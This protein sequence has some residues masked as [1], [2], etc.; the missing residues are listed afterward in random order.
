MEYL[1]YIITGLIGFGGIAFFALMAVFVE[2]KIAAYIQDRVGPNVVGP[3]GLF[4]TFA[5]ILK[6]LMKEQIIPDAVDRRLFVLA[7][8]IVFISVFAGFAVIPWGAGNSAIS[9]SASLVFVIAIVS[10]EV[11]GMWMA[12]WSS[13]NKYSLLGAIR[14]IAQMV[15]YEIPVALALLSAV[16]LVGSLDLNEICRLQGIHGIPATSWGGIFAWNIFKY[17]HL[18]L[19]FIIYAIASLAECNRAPFDLPEA[20][21]EI[22]AGFHTEYSGFRFALF[23]LAEYSNM[24]LVSLL[25]VIVFWGGWN[26]PFPDI[27]F[28]SAA[29]EGIV[30]TN[31]L[32][33]WGKLTT[34]IPGTWSGNLWGTFWLLSKATLWVLVQMWIRWTF[35]RI[36]VDQLMSL[37]WK[38][39][40]PAGI[41]LVLL[42]GLIKIL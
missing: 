19:A 42:S 8:I 13:N 3:Y 22:I 20:E 10:V 31:S 37:C 29:G 6:L 7:P 27:S 30:S 18:I 21:S 1:P 2:R 26:S 24:L 39:F 16:V 40:V 25:G 15:S 11:I 33:Q 35:P 41:G 23:M 32:L 5:D 34:G 9:L 14:A 38:V 17:P 36:R 28:N 4:Q 12:G